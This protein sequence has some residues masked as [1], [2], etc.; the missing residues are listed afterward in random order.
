MVRDSLPA[1][2]WYVW[3]LSIAAHVVAALF[4]LLFP[5]VADEAMPLPAPLASLTLIAATIVPPSPPVSVPRHA[6]S[7]AEA[8]APAEAPVGISKQSN[9]PA[10][11]ADVP[12]IEGG[13]PVEGGFPPG[14]GGAGSMVNVPVPPPT[15]PSPPTPK[16]PVR[17]GQ[18]I[19]EPRKI[20]NVT[21]IYPEIAMKN[22]VEGIV[23]LEATLDEHGT[24]Q[25]VRVLRSV[26]LLDQAAVDA[27]KRWRYT[28]TLLN[29]APVQV[30]LTIT[31]TFKI[32]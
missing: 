10:P 12:G 2:R 19:R 23:V 31:V 24:V 9:D 17:V 22:H 21:P 15:P 11:R 26:P 29:G 16:E 1:P 6:A 14:A 7:A 8:V 30:L 5:L 18:G 4:V 32:Q 13:L 3:P 20:V 28:P 27:V 25:N